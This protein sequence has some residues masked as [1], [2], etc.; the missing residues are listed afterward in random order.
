MKEYDPEFLKLLQK[1][2]AQSVQDLFYGRTAE[3]PMACQ[4][5]YTI[6]FRFVDV[7]GDGSL[8]HDCGELV[9]FRARA[10]Q[11]FWSHN[12]KKAGEPTKIFCESC[13]ECREN[14]KW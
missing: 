5:R 12:G 4:A 9:F 14:K 6:D 10:L 1:L 8:C 11:G 2:V 7:E 3:N 13:A